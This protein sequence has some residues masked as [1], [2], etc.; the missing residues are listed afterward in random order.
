MTLPPHKR[1]R[2][3]DRGTIE[4]VRRWVEAFVIDLNLCPFA[5]RELLQE[6][7]RFA[8]TRSSNE[9]DLLVALEAELELL[10]DDSAVET[11]LLI[12]PEVLQDFHDYNQFLELSEGLLLQMGLRDVFQI[13]SFHPS[14]QFHGTDMEA[15][16]NYTN[17][18]PYP[19]LHLI[20]EASLDRVLT[21][22]PNPEEIPLRNI[23]RMKALG[24][25]RLEA[26]LQACFDGAEK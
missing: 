25:D 22:Y 3:E 12:H 14:Y 8:L 11:T 20:R 16:E 1:M 24:K 5:R 19:M 15:V 21:S 9:T 4:T 23:E 26:A 6:R 13:A 18:S 10:I 17:R 7:I 2:P